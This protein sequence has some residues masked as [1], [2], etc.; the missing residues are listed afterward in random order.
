MSTW[1]VPAIGIAPRAPSTPG[2]LGADQHRDQDRERRQ[3]DGTAVDDRLQHVVL[4][5]LV[6]DEVHEDDQPDHPPL[7]DERD[8][9][10]QD[11]RQGRP[12]Q[13]NEIEDRHEEAERDR[14][15]DAGREQHDRRHDSG[16]D[17][18]QQVAGDVAS[19]RPV[20]VVA[21]PP[22]S[23]LRRLGQECVEAFQ[24]ARALEQHEERQ[25]RDRHHGDD[26]G[27]DSLRD[28]HR[29]ARESRAPARRRPSR[30]ASRMRSTTSYRTASSPSCPRP[31]V[32]SST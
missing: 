18:D 15:G 14:I 25:E 7:V 29:R 8:R 17:A 19:D 2:Q 23:F 32:T 10:D 24:P 11:R 20:D 22:P 26:G 16:Y 5:L 21:H 27:Q 31:S 6:E 9:R 3:L 13:R 12:R 4:E 30:P 28:R 1:I